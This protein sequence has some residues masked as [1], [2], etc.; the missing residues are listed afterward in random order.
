MRD[1]RFLVVIRNDHKTTKA[2]AAF[3]YISVRTKVSLI[4]VTFSEFVLLKKSVRTS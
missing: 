2:K 1:G 4:F 3:H